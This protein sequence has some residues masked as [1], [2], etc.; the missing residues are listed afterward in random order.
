MET[1]LISAGL[2]V[3]RAIRAG[4]E[5]GKISPEDI[6]GLLVEM[7]DFKAKRDAAVG[8]WDAAAPSEPAPDP[9]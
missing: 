7:A 5:A 9:E 8:A 6:D 2:E 1:L 4:V 3:I